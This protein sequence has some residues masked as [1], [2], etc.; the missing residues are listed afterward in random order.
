VLDTVASP[1]ATQALTLDSLG[2][3]DGSTVTGI[4]TTEARTF[5]AQNQ[6][7]LNSGSTTPTYDDDGNV[8]EDDTGN[9]QSLEQHLMARD[10]TIFGPRQGATTRRLNQTSR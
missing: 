8:T 2:N 5:N 7:T 3:W 1:T 9:T 6:I 4:G 10:D